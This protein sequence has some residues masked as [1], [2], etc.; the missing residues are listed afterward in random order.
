MK[1]WRATGSVCDLKKPLKRIVLTEE[2]VQN[3]E[4]QL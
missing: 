2:E 3:I 4:A 1:K